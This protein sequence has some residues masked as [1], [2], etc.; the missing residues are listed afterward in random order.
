MVLRAAG[1]NLVQD[2]Q[3]LLGGWMSQPEALI[4]WSG[5]LIAVAIYFSLIYDNRRL[6]V[7]NLIADQRVSLARERAYASLEALEKTSTEWKAMRGA[8]SAVGADRVA[9]RTSKN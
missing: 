4:K 2:L 5:L 9:D 7:S 3:N 6:E 1:I 8:I